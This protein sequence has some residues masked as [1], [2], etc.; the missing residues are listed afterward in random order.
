VKHGSASVPFLFVDAYDILDHSVLSV[1]G[2]EVEPVLERT[3]GL[4]QSS[5]AHT[6][7]GLRKGRLSFDGY[8]DDGDLGTLAA[9]IAPGGVSRLVTTGVAGNTFGAPVSIMTGAFAGKVRRGPKRGEITK[10]GGDLVTSGTVHL[11][12]ILLHPLTT[13]SSTGDTQGADSVDNGASS[14]AGAVA[15]LHVK[16]CAGVTNVVVKVRHSADDTTYADL[17]TFTAVTPWTP[18]TVPPAVAA[19]LASVAGTVNRHLAVSYTF[20]GAGTIEF[21]VGVARG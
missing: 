21:A 4:G 18:P 7:V 3:D 11:G 6:P 10:A 14:A 8:F 12:A 16:A 20:T 9:L 19:Q 2:P 13:R 5:E 17:I 1:D 15:A